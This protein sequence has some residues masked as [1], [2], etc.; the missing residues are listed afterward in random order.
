MAKRMLLRFALFLSGFTTTENAYC[1]LTYLG[2]HT[3][4]LS[5]VNAR[6]KLRQDTLFVPA[7]NGLFKKSILSN[8]TNWIPAGFQGMTINDFVLIGQDTIV[9]V[10]DSLEGN[11]VFISIDNGSSFTNSTNGFGGSGSNYIAGMRIDV[12][13]FN[14]HEIIGLSGACV[15]RSLDFCTTWTPIYLNWGYFYYQSTTLQYHPLNSTRIYS[16]GEGGF[17]SSEL[18]YSLNGGTSWASSAV[19]S[20]N[21]VN[22]L[23]FHPAETDTLV[24]GM[25]GR[26]RL[27]ADNGI[28]WSDVFMT[29]HYEYILSIVYD[30]SNTNILY[31]AGAING[32]NDTL[33][34]FRSPDGGTSWVQYLIAYLPNDGGAVMSMVMHNNSLFML[35]TD[36]SRNCRGVY[37]VDLSSVAVPDNVNQNYISVTPNPFSG[38]VSLQTGSYLNDATLKVFNCLGEPVAEVKN[39]SGNAV[40][41]NRGNLPAGLYLLM[42]QEGNNPPGIA[43]V[44]IGD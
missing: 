8:D 41:F 40:T 22:T 10:V 17:F 35:T 30:E 9:C 20:N 37:K 18:A 3:Q 14:H 15:A 1:Q 44:I 39:I 23:A 12:N 26:I 27:S 13:P 4:K 36:Y 34:I 5:I 29:P 7:R 43:K 32:F 42:L 16:G 19:L 2:L 24:I 21:A 11:T 31:A 28:T 25:E 38:S 6:M 33:R